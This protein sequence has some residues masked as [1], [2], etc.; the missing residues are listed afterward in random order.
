[1]EQEQLSNT[2][3]QIA[4]KILGRKHQTNGTKGIWQTNLIKVAAD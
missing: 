4:I 2:H 3:H 1:L